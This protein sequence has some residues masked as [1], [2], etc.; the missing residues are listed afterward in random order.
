MNAD[1]SA[2][3]PRLGVGI[4]WR[5]ELARAIERRAGLG[6]VEIVAENIP[7]AAG[8]GEF[9]IPPALQRLRDRGIRVIPH[10]IS[11]S[12][13]GAEL[14][15][16]ARLARLDQLARQLDAPLVSEHIA[17]VRAGG[18]EAGHLLPVQRTR[19]ALEIL[20][21]N[22]RRAQD[23]LSVPLAL[24]NI[25]ALFDWPDA[26]LGEA[27]FIAEL[28]DRTGAWLLLDVANVHANSRNL[29]GN[30]ASFFDALPLDRLAYVHM[31]GG[32]DRQGIYHDTHSHAIPA[33]ALELLGELARRVE[34]PG[35]MLERDDN[36]P[37]ERE[38]FD[39]LDAIESAVSQK[40]RSG[41]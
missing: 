30:A 7:R 32:E 37:S 11:L 22:V 5:P 21:E 19:A 8:E 23:R 35:V 31:G 3:P 28:L 17:F 9:I 26:E 14:P 40:S 24:E 13:G 29:G 36:F 16:V 6:F 20:V 41:P 33:G 2:K 27:E 34:I 15:D 1:R 38:L 39:E 4:G 18:R 12:L 10:G 25:S